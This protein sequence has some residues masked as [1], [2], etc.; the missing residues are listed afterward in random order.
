MG[1]NVD[2]VVWHGCTQQEQAVLQ[3]NEHGVVAGALDAPELE[4]EP[5]D[6]SCGRRAASSI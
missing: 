5:A 3:G 1:A 4:D 2:G 6:E